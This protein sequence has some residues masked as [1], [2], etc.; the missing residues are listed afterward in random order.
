MQTG[1]P[2]AHVRTGYALFDDRHVLVDANAEI[3]GGGARACDDFPKMDLFAVIAKLLPHFRRFDGLAVEPT[4]EFARHAAVRWGQGNVLPVEAQ[5]IDGS[6]RLLTSHPRPEGGIAL[7]S[8][9]ITEM[10]RAQIAHLENAEIFRCITDSHPLPVWVVDEESKQILYESLDASNMLGRKWRPQ[11]PQH[12]TTHFTDPCEFEEIRSLAGKY[13]IV[14]DHEIQLRRTDGSTVWCST[15]CR[16]AAYRGRPALIIGVLDITERKQ[17]EDLFGFLIKHHPLPVWMNDAGSGEVIYRSDAAERLFGW[18]EEGDRKTLPLADHFVDREQYLEI[19]R[20]LMRNGVVEN[21]E[22]LLKSANGREFWVNGNL[23]VVEFQGRRVVLAGIADVTKQKKRDGEVALAREMLANAVESLSEGFALYDEDHRLVMCNRLYRE[24]NHPVAELIKPGM[25]WM[26]MLR[27]SVGRGMYADAVGREDQWLNDR[28]QNRAEFRSRYEAD[29]GNGKWHSVSMHS[30][31]LGGFVVTRADISE[32]KKA[33]AAEREATVLLQKVLDA[34]PA[35]TQMSSTDGQTLYRN[36]ACRELYGDRRQLMDHYVDPN[37]RN[38]LID[39]LLDRGRIDDFRLRQY[40]AD[41]RIFWASL[42]ARLIDFQGRQVIVSNATDISDMIAAQEQTRQANERLTDAIESLGEGFALYDKDDCLV[43]ANSRYRNMHAISADVLTQG[44]NWFNFLRTAAERNQF[45]VPAGKI[46][47]WLAERARDRREF[48]QQEFQ[49][50]NGDWYFVS[51]C[52]TREGGFVVTRLDITERKRAELAAKEADE[53]VR[54]VLEVCSVNIQMTRAHDGKLLYRSPATIDLLGE[55][56]SAIDYYVNPMDRMQFVERLLRDGSVDDFETQ[57]RRKNGEQCWCSISSRLID[58]HGEKVIVS[59]TYDLTY[60]IEM[61][62]QLEHQRETLHQNEK[63]SALGGLLAGVAHELNNPLSVVLG[64]SLMMKE[65][66]T[67]AKAAERAG[68]ISKAAE[69]CARIV[70]TFL[71][72]ARQ[73]PARTSNVTIDEIV[74]AAVEVA[75]Y[76]IQSSDIELSV[77]LEP[78]LP[79]IWADPDQLSQVLINLLVNAEQA[80]HDWGGQRKITVSTRLHPKSGNV[81]VSVADTGPGIPREI[82]SRIFEPFFT[83]KEVGAG[84][85]IGLSFCHRIVQSH[86]GIIQVETTESGQST[87]VVSL[88][89]SDRLD[90]VAEIAA[91]EP[92]TPAGLACLV[93]DDEREVGGMIADVL[94]QDGFK[95]VVAGSGE[96]AL[97]QLNKRTFALILSDLK[98]PNMNGRHLFNHISEC[99]P[100][101]VSKLAFLTGDTISPDSQVFLRATKRPYLEKPI[102]PSDLRNFV[103]RLVSK[104]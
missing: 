26:D 62:R 82:L 13:E 31:D 17:R 27:E 91:E 47:E 98:M 87:F 80:L 48:R 66:A 86:G 52:P 76:S 24:M 95:V 20:E 72:M 3:L 4:D 10:K 19:S 92:P 41:D 21:C 74:A 42:S 94:K 46:D 96:E 9:D 37:D 33:E 55:V 54:K 99:H 22:A 44:V 77:D 100:A 36:P 5:T 30:T 18:V 90:E 104:I 29:L 1:N 93:V 65:S 53:M 64:L 67:D 78:D 71:A 79:V 83:T 89:A 39:A 50:T 60:H 8:I 7:V 45:P 73:Q 15:N 34:C 23:R 14:R 32:R 12:I 16:R 35:P 68:K 75:E 51:N 49:H 59:H 43:L 102:K 11:E 25:K 81:V 84:T 103:S 88:P 101:E 85:G 97:K 6:W 63:M 57:L 40:A 56:A 61:Q 38:T 70:K 28:I 69:R 2:A 58:F